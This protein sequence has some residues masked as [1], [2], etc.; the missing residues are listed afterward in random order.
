[1]YIYSAW[2]PYFELRARK[3]LDEPPLGRKAEGS[4][5]LGEFLYATRLA[6][7]VAFGLAPGVGVMRPVISFRVRARDRND[8][9]SEQNI[10]AKNE[11]FAENSAISKNQR[12]CAE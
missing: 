6:S 7:P 5:S 2:I 1:M 4:K 8:P 10:P 12:K 3:V 9:N 11:R